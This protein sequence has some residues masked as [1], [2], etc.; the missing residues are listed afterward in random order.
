M[1]KPELVN[2]WIEDISTEKHECIMTEF[3]N[4][5]FTLDSLL[6]SINKN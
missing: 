4:E 1:R 5:I 2:S 6:S 3:K